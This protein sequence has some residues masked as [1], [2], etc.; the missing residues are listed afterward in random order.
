MILIPVIPTKRTVV[1]L[2]GSKL[3]LF[4]VWEKMQRAWS[5]GQKRP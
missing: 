3:P 5:I 4:S 2:M 1:H